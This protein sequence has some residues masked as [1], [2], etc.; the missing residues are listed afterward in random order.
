M[1]DLKKIGEGRNNCQ[2][3]DASLLYDDIKESYGIEEL[4]NECAKYKSRIY[5]FILFTKK[6]PFVIKVL[7][8][9]DFWNAFDE[10]S[11]PNWPIFSV[12]PLQQGYA[13]FIG[14][15]PHGAGMMVSRWHEPEQ[16]RPFIDFFGIPNSEKL[17]CF[18]TF[19]W[20]DDDELKSII[21]PINGKTEEDVYSS[22]EK[23]ISTISY[24]ESRI[25]E[26]NKTTE[27]IF[28]EVSQDLEANHFR[29]Q[30][31]EYIKKIKELKSLLSV[32]R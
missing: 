30:I 31:G 7:R 2:M 16:N 27:N 20:G 23:I 5:G 19:I 9:S 12:K 6:N 29:S 24:A 14:A 32:F 21:T 13:D 28:R 22:I 4:R 25:S 10:L 15:S 17:P 8:D 1:S 26:E 18:V 3:V 11:G